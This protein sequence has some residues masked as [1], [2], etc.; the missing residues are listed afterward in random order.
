MSKQSQS[1]RRKFLQQTG[2]ISLL[3]TASPLN[4][5]AAKEKAEE[6][7]L[8]QKRKIPSADVIGAAVTGFGI[9]RNYNLQT[10]LKV[11]GVELACMGATNL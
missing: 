7:T 6:R 3:A 5:L 9:Q 11:P 2:T 4:S 1:S 8:F 10:A